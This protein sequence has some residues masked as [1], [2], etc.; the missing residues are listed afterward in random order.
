VAALV[1]RK[2]DKA[3]VGPTVGSGGVGVWR[4]SGFN[5]YEDVFTFNLDYKEIL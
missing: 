2:K 3:V 5:R 1:A 4:E